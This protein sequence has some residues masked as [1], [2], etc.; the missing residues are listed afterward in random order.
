[1]VTRHGGR[2]TLRFPYRTINIIKQTVNLCYERL[3][4]LLGPLFEVLQTMFQLFDVVLITE[5]GYQRIFPNAFS[6]LVIGGSD[7]LHLNT[8][9]FFL[10]SLVNN[11]PKPFTKEVSKSLSVTL[12]N[13][14]LWSTPAPV[15]AWV[16]H[17]LK[18]KGMLHRNSSFS[19]SRASIL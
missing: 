15:P 18:S 13:R 3:S 6:Q 8:R 1:M 2:I 9:M 17:L 19:F 7:G 4:S 16:P 11:S 10:S 12:A 14:L 5:S